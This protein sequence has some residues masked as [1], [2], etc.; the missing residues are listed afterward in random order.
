[1]QCVVSQPWAGKVEQMCAVPGRCI[2][3]TLSMALIVD[4]GKTYSAD[5]FV[6]LSQSLRSR[7]D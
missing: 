1:V 5:R 3:R 7:L 2:E 4:Y 6:D